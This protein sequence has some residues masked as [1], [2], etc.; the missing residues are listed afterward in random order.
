MQRMTNGIADMKIPRIGVGLPNCGPQASPDGI[1]AV[2]TAAERL[3][4]DS[5]W[6]FERLLLPK[7]ADGG[8]RYGLPETNALVYD[9]LETLTW[10]AAQTTRV[11]LGTS[12]LDS[13]FQP[14]IVL[15]RRLATLD[16]LSGGRV[17]A[18][19]GQGWM[20][21]EFAAAGI[22]LSRRGAGFEDHLAAMRACW[23]SDPVDHNGPR[24]Q[25]PR[26]EIG[27]KPVNGTIPVLIGGVSQPAVERAARLGDGF[28]AVFQDWES[29]DTQIGWYR[30]AGGTGP[31]VLRVNPER[32]DAEG[33]ASPF[34]LEKSSALYDL[35]R[36]ATAGADEVFFDL[37]H[38]GLDSSRQV[39]TF[40]GLAAMLRG[41]PPLSS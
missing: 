27:P 28:A 24:Y 36:A 40:E 29:L 26:A 1:L 12:V 4:F 17:V 7:P 10:V 23:A 15:A 8:N 38:V 18:G 11:R 41:Q 5:L 22:P 2:A 20:P 39:A 37:N 13:L 9:P 6:T 32:V 21:E 30:A 31:I 34:N 33:P 35:T 14:P 25:I 3:G 19:I 16:H